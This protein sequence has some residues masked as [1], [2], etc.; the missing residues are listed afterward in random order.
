VKRAKAP[1]LRFLFAHPA[2][3]LALGFGAGLAPIAPGTFGTLVALPLAAVLRAYAS[4]AAYLG[5]VVLAFGIGVWAAGRTGRDLGVG[6]HGAI[7]WDEVVAFVL[8]LFFVDADPLREAFAFL[9][10]RLFDI[11]KPPPARFVDREWHGGFGVMADDIVAAFYTLLVL[12][13]WQRLIG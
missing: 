9:L 13:L 2:H 4:D 1:T 5:A 11:A 12:A 8:V 3:F 10:F 6:D 7:V